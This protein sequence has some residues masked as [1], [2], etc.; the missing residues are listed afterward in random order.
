MTLL[1]HRPHGRGPGRSYKATSAV[2]ALSILAL[3][4]IGGG[5]RG[6]DIGGGGGGGAPSGAAGGDLGGTYPNP[7]VVSVADV[8]TGTLPVANGGTGVT[9]KTGTGNVVLST[10]PTLVTPTLGAAQATSLQFTDTTLARDLSETLS[11]RDGANPQNLCIM[12]TF[13]DASNYACLS[14]KW[15]ANQATIGVQGAGTGATNRQI[16]IVSGSKL[17]LGSASSFGVALAV[18]GTEMWN[19]DASG[20]WIAPSDNTKDIGASGAT[21]PRTGYFGSAVVAGTTVQ[22]QTKYSAAGTP[23]PTCNSAAEGTNASVSDATTPTF[24]GTYASGGAVHERVYCNGTN[25]LDD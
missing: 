13:T 21:R 8:T 14:L 6:Q 3:L 4:S 17:S 11:V 12:N 15:S 22:T 18:G 24:H 23:L 16:N 7:T 10:S 1:A 19:V 25:W 9:A 2:F 5:A 20:N